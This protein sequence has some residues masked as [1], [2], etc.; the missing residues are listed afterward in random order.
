M[1]ASVWSYV[2]EY[3]PDLGAAFA[4]LQAKVLA[5]GDYWWAVRDASARGFA[6]RPRDI[7]ELFRDEHV[8]ES[9]THSILDMDRVLGPGEAPDYG[10]MAEI[11]NVT[12][13]LE[14]SRLFTTLGQPEYG[15]VAPVTAA[16]AL[17]CV[18]VEKLTRDHLEAIEDLG[19]Y[20]GFGRCAVLHD[21][22]GKPDAICF[23]GHSGD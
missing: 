3:Q 6:D 8:Q 19:G 4:A 21:A 12:S 20:R 10:W 2:V 11:D 17:E 13:P 9:G 23:W 7:K 22:D 18:G 16:E 1:G 5:E 15:T 14:L